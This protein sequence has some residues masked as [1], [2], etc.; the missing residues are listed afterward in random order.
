M[1]A[2]FMLLIGVSLLASWNTVAWALE[3]ILLVALGALIFAR[4][5]SGSYVFHLLIGHGEFAKRTLPWT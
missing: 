2:S 5:V 4:S 1:A 3:A